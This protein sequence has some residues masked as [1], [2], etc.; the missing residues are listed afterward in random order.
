MICVEDMDQ[1]MEEEISD[2][3]T[4]NLSSISPSNKIYFIQSDH[5][6][7]LM[8]EAYAS[9]RKDKLNPCWLDESKVK[10]IFET[11]FSPIFVIN[12]FQGKFFESLKKIENVRI[13]SPFAI[14]QC[15]PKSIEF[16]P[17]RK[18]PILNLCMRRCYITHSNIQDL[19]KLSDIKNKVTS[20]G[21]Q[22]SHKLIKK[23]TQ[24]V[25]NSWTSKKCLCARQRGIPVMSLEWIEK[26]WEESNKGIDAFHT[27]FRKYRLP[28]F[29][30]MNICT[31]G[32]RKF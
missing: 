32:V 17:E 13:F 26:C 5:N 8:I 22:F 31:S 14:I 6:S 9:L 30:N 12:S 28:I 3:S 25:S 19:E 24:I 23:I 29:K 10:S 18:Y 11:E 16:L 2:V 15:N 20:M 4:N 1:E 27:S 7:R 21:G